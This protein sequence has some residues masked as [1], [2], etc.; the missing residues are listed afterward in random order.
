MKQTKGKAT[1]T[2]RI[3]PKAQVLQVEKFEISYKNYE[4]LAR[5]MN[6]R[7]KISAR[8]RTSLSAKDQRRLSREIKRARHL[9]LLPFKARI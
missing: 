8:K 4:R 3:M 5:F 7:A 6:D 9:A 1:R 2:R